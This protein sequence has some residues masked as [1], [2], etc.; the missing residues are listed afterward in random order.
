MIELLILALGVSMDAAAVSAAQAAAAD[1][2]PGSL[3][4]RIAVVFGVFQ[5][6]MALAG[7]AG[8][9]GLNR[10]VATWDHWIAFTLLVI[11]GLR[12]IIPSKRTDSTPATLTPTA[13]FVLAFA[14]SIDSFAVGLTL[15]LL[16]VDPI[17]A[18]LLIGLVT[19]V[20]CLITGSIGQRLGVRFGRKAG[21]A[22]GIALLGIGTHILISHLSA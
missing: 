10:V 14:T 6:A 5:S 13:L 19:F 18:V 15:P 11:V 20:I 9:I 3:T 21:I 22:G 8:G 7:W 4:L 16:A 12:M 1:A 2:R 17:L